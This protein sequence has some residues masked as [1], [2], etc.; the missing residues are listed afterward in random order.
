M[1]SKGF[2]YFL[3]FNFRLIF[4][5]KQSIIL[6]FYLG[7]KIYRYRFYYCQRSNIAPVLCRIAERFGYLVLSG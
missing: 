7:R 1:V 2:Y 5:L 4:T 3:Y 6:Y